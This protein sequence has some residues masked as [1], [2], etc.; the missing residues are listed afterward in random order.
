MGDVNLSKNGG[1][2]SGLIGTDVLNKVTWIGDKNGDVDENRIVI[3]GTDGRIRYNATTVGHN[4]QGKVGIGLDPTVEFETI[5][6]VILNSGG[7]TSLILN[8]GI[9]QATITGACFQFSRHR[10]PC[11]NS[12][13]K[14]SVICSSRFSSCHFSISRFNR[15]NWRK[16]F[17][18]Y[19]HPISRWYI[20][21]RCLFNNYCYCCKYNY[22]TSNLY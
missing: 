7:T 9:S 14:W 13:L 5:G 3:N 2:T 15:V 4:F 6:D 10:N 20:Q 19:Y 22:C 1:Y 8:N 11:S 16:H 21:N 17:Y 18:S 12:K